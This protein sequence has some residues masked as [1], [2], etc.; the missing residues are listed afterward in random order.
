MENRQFHSQYK[1][2]VDLISAALPH[3]D[4]RTKA[5]MEVLIKAGELMD[6][7][8]SSTSPEISA[9]D[10]SNESVDLEALLTSLQSACNPQELEL[11]NTILNFQKTRKLYRT[12]QSMKDYLP[13]GESSNFTRNQILPLI[14]KFFEHYQSNFERSPSYEQ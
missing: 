4:S 10:V 8:Q 13:S 12:Y 7:F 14:E 11:V 6:S 9:C 3:V 1:H 5:N 2:A